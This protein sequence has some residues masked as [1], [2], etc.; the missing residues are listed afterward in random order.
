MNA[1]AQSFKYRSRQP[2]GKKTLLAPIAASIL[3]RSPLLLL[4]MCILLL[5]ACQSGK[6][7]EAARPAPRKLLF[8]GDSF[9]FSNGG[10]DHHVRELAASA[11]PP[12]Q[13]VADSDTQGGAPLRVLFGR[14][15]VHEKIRQGGYDVVIL[16]DDIPE[17]TEHSPAA[18]HEFSRRF[19]QEIKAAGAK[20]CLFMAWPYERLNWVTLEEIDQ[21]HQTASRELG[22]SAAPVGVAF[23]R[24]LKARPTLPMLGSDKE[25]E[26]NPGTYLAACVIY[27]T[28]F[29]ENPQGLA[30]RPEGVSSEEAEFLQRIAW[31]TV[32][33]WRH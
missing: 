30:Y 2:A 1:S 20:T 10:L 19:D 17:Y 11:Q 9:T 23:A 15:S 26:S 28:I 22:A 27:A 14:P 3:K 8:V 29:Q 33:A 13:I 6:P 7:S 12:R 18:F 25:H 24:S 21:A 31:E 16:Q 32:S 5:P 4:L